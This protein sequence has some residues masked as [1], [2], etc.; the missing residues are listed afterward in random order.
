MRQNTRA[1]QDSRIGS[2]KPVPLTVEGAVTPRKAPSGAPPQQEPLETAEQEL[3]RLENDERLVPYY[4]A[5]S[6]M[7]PF[8]LPKDVMWIKRLIVSIS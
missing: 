2:K 3:A 1:P 8:P 5:L 6:R 4:S 7:K